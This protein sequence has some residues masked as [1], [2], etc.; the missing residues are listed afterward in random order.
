VKSRY[1]IIFRP[2]KDSPW[3]ESDDPSVKESDFS[4]EFFRLF[5][6]GGYI[7]RS[8]INAARRIFDEEQGLVPDPPAIDPA[9]LSSQSRRKILRHLSQSISFRRAHIERIVA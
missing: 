1:H 4:A 9:Q 5:F 6:T 7:D 3:F 8:K 2:G